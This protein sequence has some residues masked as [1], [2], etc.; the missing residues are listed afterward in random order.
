MH[1]YTFKPKDYMSKTAFLE[2]LEDLAYRRMLDHCYLTEKPLPENIEEIAMLIRMR[3][4]TDSIKIVL[5]YF[6]ELTAEG[7]IND[8]VVRELSAYHSKSLKAKASADARWSKKRNKVNDLCGDN[9]DCEINANALQE[10][11]ECN[12]NQQPLTNNDKPITSINN[13]GDSDKP[14]R[15]DFKKSLIEKGA[16]EDLAIAFMAVR[17][18]KKATNT[19]KAFDLFMNNVNKSNMNLNQVLEI[20]VQ[21]DWKGFDPTWIQN[22]QPSYSTPQSRQTP[23]MADYMQQEMMRDVT[24]DYQYNYLE[25]KE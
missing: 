9:S 15:F 10:E 3:S 24:P 16:T 21:R 5:H 8:Y 7:Y 4:H 19:E 11:S 17:K 13:I 20:C 23:S 22:K 2:P 14:K 6:F 1:Y 18:N 25:H 12:T